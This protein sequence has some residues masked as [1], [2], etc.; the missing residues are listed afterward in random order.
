MG[1]PKDRNRKKRSSTHATLESPNIALR[2]EM[3]GLAAK[4]EV[5]PSPDRIL[6]ILEMMKN[7][8]LPMVRFM[9]KPII[10]L[11]A[12]S[13][14]DVPV[15]FHAQRVMLV[16]DGYSYGSFMSLGLA[17][18]GKWF[19]DLFAAEAREARFQC[20]DSPDL[21]ILVYRHAKT[22]SPISTYEAYEEW[23]R[24]D[25]D[26]RFLDDIVR[27]AAI[28]RFISE[29]HKT[30]RLALKEQ[31]ERIRIQ[32]ERVE[33]IGQF[34][35]ALDPI[36]SGRNTKQLPR[37]TIFHKT[38]TGQSRAAGSS[39]LALAA[40]EPFW[41][42]IRTPA[43]SDRDRFRP[44]LESSSPSSLQNFSEY[45]ARTLAEI[46][47]SRENGE[48]PRPAIHFLHRS[49]GRMP[50]SPEEIDVLKNWAASFLR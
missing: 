43:R 48:R 50:F 33:L 3:F 4:T 41:E 21:A 23:T 5:T 32:R 2:S 34:A 47:K 44:F 12:F 38:A 25:N 6:S 20:V 46:W 7:I 18:S 39:Y 9:D 11:P 37:H 45:L 8:L 19:V 10:E 16:F 42:L 27:Y 28:V 31:E 29:C 22:L 13:K 26:F 1:S 36:V 17:R 35:G 49:D 30:M 14:A 15:A 40:L 24:A